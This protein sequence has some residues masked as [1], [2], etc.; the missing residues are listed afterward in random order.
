MLTGLYSSTIRNVTGSQFV[1]EKLS[2]VLL[3]YVE[4]VFEANGVEFP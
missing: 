2:I 4:T 3:F 1:R